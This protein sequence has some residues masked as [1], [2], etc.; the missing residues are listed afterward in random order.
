M[1]RPDAA[2]S[3]V[4]TAHQRAHARDLEGARPDVNQM[5]PDVQPLGTRP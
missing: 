2:S 1:A 3:H 4:W 5:R